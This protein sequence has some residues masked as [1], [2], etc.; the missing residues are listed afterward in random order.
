[1]SVRIREILVDING[2]FCVGDGTFIV[3][4]V[5]VEGGPVIIDG[6]IRFLNGFAEIEVV[7]RFA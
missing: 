7:E 2:L 3:F 1:M 5:N 6:L 4:H